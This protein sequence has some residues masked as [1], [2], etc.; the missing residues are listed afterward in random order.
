[1]LALYERLLNVHDS[2]DFPIGFETTI[3]TIIRI[4]G[5]RVCVSINKSNFNLRLVPPLW[6]SW[7]TI[8]KYHY[9]YKCIID[10]SIIH[11]KVL[12]GRLMS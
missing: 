12:F 1:M 9:M 3:V 4:E 8:Q 10:K 2:M 5:T 6:F 11:T 7:Y